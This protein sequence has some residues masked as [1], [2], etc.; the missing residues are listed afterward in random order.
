MT[1]EERAKVAIENAKTFIAAADSWLKESAVN[2]V[3]S[4]AT[5]GAMERAS[6]ELTRSLSAMRQWARKRS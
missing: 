6:M 4:T 3:G 2:R 1:R 5:G